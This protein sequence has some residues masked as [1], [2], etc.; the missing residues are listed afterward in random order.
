MSTKARK[1]NKITWFIK[2]PIRLLTRA[3]DFYSRSM[4]E[5]AGQFSDGPYGVIMGCPTTP[6]MFNLPRS[7]SVNSTSSKEED[8]KELMRV[9][10]TRSQG[11][12]IELEILRRRQPEQSPVAGVNAVPPSQSIGIGRIDEDKPCESCDFGG[13]IKVKKVI[14]PRSRSYAVSTTGMI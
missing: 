7:F 4:S 9:A 8:F 11:S 1:K 6:Q 12:K 3:R 13:E 2:A 14:N 10:S 5:C